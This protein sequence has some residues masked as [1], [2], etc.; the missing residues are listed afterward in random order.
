MSEGLEKRETGETMSPL[1]NVD[2][3]TLV[4]IFDT[5]V[6]DSCSCSCGC[7]DEGCGTSLTSPNIAELETLASAAIEKYGEEKRARF[8]SEISH[9]LRCSQGN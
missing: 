2:E 4:L 9:A 6:P 7:G 5:L 1:S 8:S 3:P